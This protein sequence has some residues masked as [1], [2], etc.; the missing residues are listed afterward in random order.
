[1]RRRC[2]VGHQHGHGACSRYNMTGHLLVAHVSAYYTI[3]HVTALFRAICYQTEQAQAAAQLRVPLGTRAKRCACT[4]VQTE[5]SPQSTRHASHRLGRHWRV[6]HAHTHCR[7]T[8]EANV[9]RVAFNSQL[10][11]CH[12]SQHVLSTLQMA[13]SPLRPH[14]DTATHQPLVVETSTTASEPA[15]IKA[16][17]TVAMGKRASAES[18]RRTKHEREVVKKE[19][20]VVGVR[21]EGANGVANGATAVAPTA[22]APNGAQTTTRAPNGVTRAASPKKAVD[23]KRSRDDDVHCDSTLVTTSLCLNELDDYRNECLKLE[24]VRHA[25]VYEADKRRLYHENVILSMYEME[26]EA[27]L[28]DFEQAR[29]A[30]MMK[31]LADNAEK[32]RQVEELR[33]GICKDDVVGGWQRKHE[34]ALRGRGAIDDEVDDGRPPRRTTKR[35]R[36]NSVKVNVELD[37]HQ[38]SDDLA[39]MRGEKRQ[40]EESKERERRSKK[41]K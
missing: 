21:T 18:R 37:D 26:V 13:H 27:I 11:V 41:R 9:T 33:C 31:M 4:R 7:R 24:K 2:A 39:E 17:P 25:R 8:S 14:A 22:S 40:R 5:L 1:M 34:M 6:S 30:A 10:S 19:L 3:L 20:G 32:M 28:D 38:V 15:R 29:R 23:R 12:P 16:E 36:S 35:T